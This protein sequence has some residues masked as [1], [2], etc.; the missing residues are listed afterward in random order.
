MN[1]KETKDIIEQLPIALKLL[2]NAELS[3]GNE[4]TEIGHSFPA[5]PT[6][7]FIRLAKPISKDLTMP[8]RTYL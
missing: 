6:G 4:V 5:P 2:L 1:K 7:A 3:A 8:R